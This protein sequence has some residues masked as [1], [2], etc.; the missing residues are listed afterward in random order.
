MI[1]LESLQLKGLS[2]YVLNVISDCLQNLLPALL[3]FEKNDIKENISHLETL[4]KIIIQFYYSNY[5][6]HILVLIDRIHF[7]QFFKSYVEESNKNV[8]ETFYP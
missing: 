8:R 1:L 2:D 6:K 4:K 3:F 7:L 5:S